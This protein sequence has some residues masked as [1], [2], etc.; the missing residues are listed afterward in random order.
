VEAVMTKNEILLGDLR[1]G[2]CSSGLCK[3][4]RSVAA[5]E[6]ERLTTQRDNYATAVNSKQAKIDALMLEFCPGEMSPVQRAEYTRIPWS[7]LDAVFIG[8]T[9]AFKI[10]K[11][12]FAA[13]RCAKMLG[14]WVHVG[15]INTADRCRNWIGLADSCDGSGMSRFDHMLEDVLAMIRGTHPQSQLLEA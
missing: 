9:D 7:D 2:L 15:R 11:Q 14:M 10:S 12:A 3:E 5:D 4:L 1:Q 6:I 8:G 13:A